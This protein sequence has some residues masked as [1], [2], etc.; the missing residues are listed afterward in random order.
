MMYTY[1]NKL[2]DNDRRFE[3]FHIPK[4]GVIEHYIVQC[5]NEY[6]RDAWVRDISDA[7]I[8]AGWSSFPPH[9]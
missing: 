3:L 1:P 5:K 7:M 6:S 8:A 4:G 9:T 2:A